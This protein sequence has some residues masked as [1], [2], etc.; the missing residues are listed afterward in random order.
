MKVKQ[1]VIWLLVL[2]LLACV[3]TVLP[4]LLASGANCW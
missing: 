1:Y 2:L 4:C 3:T